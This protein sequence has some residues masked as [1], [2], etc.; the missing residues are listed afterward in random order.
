MLLVGGS[1]A[2]PEGRSAPVPP[3][4]VL[5]SSACLSPRSVAGVVFWGGM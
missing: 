3:Y 1:A 2:R 4:A 5:E